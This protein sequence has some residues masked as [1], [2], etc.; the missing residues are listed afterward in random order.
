MSFPAFHRAANANSHT[1]AWSDSQEKPKQTSTYRI[2][3]RNDLS[4]GGIFIT[5]QTQVGDLL[6]SFTGRNFPGMWMAL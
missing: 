3:T 6:A 1:S 2:L 4:I 5:G